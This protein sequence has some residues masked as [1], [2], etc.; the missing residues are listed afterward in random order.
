MATGLLASGLVGAGPALAD[1]QP[2][3]YIDGVPYVGSEMRRQYNYD[4]W[5]CRN[6]DG[7]SDGITLEWL[8]DG[9]TLPQER[10]GEITDAEDREPE[11]GG[12]R[13]N[14]AAE[15]ADHGEA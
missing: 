13:A 14:R 1:Y 6:P 7:S 8:R 3:P 15:G 11:P 2:T 10:Q 12:P 4:Y 9:E 5:G